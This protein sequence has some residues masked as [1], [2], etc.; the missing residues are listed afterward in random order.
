MGRG[1]SKAGGG[2]AEV[3]NG[4]GGNPASAGHAGISPI[5][6]GKESQADPKAIPQTVSRP[7]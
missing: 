4:C 6:Q 5:I 3:R 7:I 1:G 2:R